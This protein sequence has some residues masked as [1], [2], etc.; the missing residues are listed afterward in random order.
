MKKIT[1]YIITGLLPFN[2]VFAGDI[3]Q[4]TQKSRAAIKALGGELKSTLQTSMKASGPTESISVC[5]TIAPEISKKISEEK[6]MSVA[7]TS[8]K[9]RNPNNKPDE[10]EKSVLLQ[11]EQRKTQGEAVTTLDYSELTEHEG[12]KVFRY[13]K[14][15]PTD[16]V[17]L[18]CHGSNITQPVASKINSL[19]PEDK[20]TGFKKGD[21]R[22]AFTVIQTV[23]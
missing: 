3:E 20:A 4:L 13:M 22:G 6:G 21:I 15:I 8:L 12:K 7:R 11:F 19:Y 18:N 10:W 9:Y 5:N 2:L 1:A 16:E 17:C 14:A 23:N